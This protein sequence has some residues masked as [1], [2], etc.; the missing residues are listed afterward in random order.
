[1]RQVISHRESPRRRD[2]TWGPVIVDSM[3]PVRIVGKGINYDADTAR[4]RGE[5]LR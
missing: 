3:R 1:M 2:E 4:M 5:T